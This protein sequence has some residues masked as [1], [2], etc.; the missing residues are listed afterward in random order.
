MRSEKLTFATVTKP[1]LDRLQVL[2]PKVLPFVDR[3][4]IVV[5]E[6]N[7]EVEQYLKSLGPKVELFYYKWHDNFA[8]SWNAYLQQ[9]VDGWVMILDDDEVPSDSMLESLD[10]Y[11]NGSARGEKYCAIGFRCNPISEGQDMGPCNYYRQ[12]FFRRAPGMKYV[13]ADKE[14]GCHQCLVGY[15]NNR[16][17]H[18]RDHEVYYHIKPLIDEY[19]NASRN[20]WT[21]SIW[22]SDTNIYRSEEWKELKGLVAKYHP[23]VQTFPDFDRV[24]TDGRLDEK[25]KEWMVFWYNERR[26]HPHMNE[27]RAL[28]IYYFIY[29]HPEE[30][31]RYGF[32][33]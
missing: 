18:S 27:M 2:V 19:R 25:I 7:Q 28:P 13:S 22:V 14:S 3:A 12:V 4:V 23:E 6:R 5:G 21:Y 26:E 20:Y 24:M 30:S 10:G 15:P 32:V 1:H 31:E 11:I 8:A 16:I 33:K 17:I 9:I 29:L